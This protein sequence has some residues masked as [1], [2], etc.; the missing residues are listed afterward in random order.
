MAV[1]NH[2]TSRHEA[3]QRIRR[4]DENSYVIYKKGGKKI[5]VRLLPAPWSHV[6]LIAALSAF[7]INTCRY[8][9]VH[10]F[11]EPEIFKYNAKLEQRYQDQLKNR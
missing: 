7:A 1:Q 8:A 2:R 11:G 4:E 9:W 5:R 6:I 10:T 3:F